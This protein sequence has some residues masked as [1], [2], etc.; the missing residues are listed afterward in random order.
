M[1]LLP[2]LS[3]CIQ[4][5]GETEGL[6][7]SDRQALAHHASRW[8]EFAIDNICMQLASTSLLDAVHLGGA[9]TVSFATPTTGQQQG[10]QQRFCRYG[11]PGRAEC[12]MLG[13]QGH[14]QRNIA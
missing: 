4:P 6:P 12:A 2:L 9:D 10:S 1:D 14:I 13:D 7:Q 8:R 11:C 5:E 3:P